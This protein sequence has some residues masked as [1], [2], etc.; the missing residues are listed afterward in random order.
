MA[1]KR[2]WENK[3]GCWHQAST[4]QIYYKD[5]TIYPTHTPASKS[6]LEAK[7][8]IKHSS[9]PSKDKVINQAWGDSERSIFAVFGQGWADVD[10]KTLIFFTSKQKPGHHRQSKPEE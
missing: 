6:G 7:E 10:Q 8:R 4:S 2:K 9:P 3:R 1:E 5:R